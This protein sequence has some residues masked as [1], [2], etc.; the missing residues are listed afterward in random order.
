MINQHFIRSNLMAKPS[1]TD[2]GAQRHAAGRRS[3]WEL[4]A[5]LAALLSAC[6]GGSSSTSG[7]ATSPQNCVT[8]SEV[9]PFA[10]VISHTHEYINCPVTTEAAFALA[11]QCVAIQANAGEVLSLLGPNGAGKSTTIS[12]LSGLLASFA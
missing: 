4:F 6:S 7:S 11:G 8:S 9:V 2:R 5:L 12:M 1:R 3:A 10:R